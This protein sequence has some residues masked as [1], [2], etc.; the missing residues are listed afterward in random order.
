MPH[1]LGIDHIALTVRDLG[2]SEPFYER[3]FG[4]P[5]V[6]DLGGESLRRRIFALPSGT[7]IGLTQHD[8]APGEGAADAFSPFRPGL[9]HLGFGVANREELQGWADH[10]TAAGIEHSGLVEVPYG[11]ALSLKD[12]DGIALE[13]FLGL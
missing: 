13:F 10:L 8:G 1:L 4:F 2:A 6:A 12:P 5:A 3:M 9:D 11:I 7:T